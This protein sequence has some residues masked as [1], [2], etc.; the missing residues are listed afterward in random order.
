MP[1][2][3]PNI[4]RVAVG[5]VHHEGKILLAQRPEGKD[6]AGFWEFPGGKIEANEQV[7][8]ALVRELAEEVNLQL[9]AHQF[10]PLLQVTFNYP[11]KTVSLETLWVEA[12]AAQVQR[13]QGLEGQAIRWVALADLN[14]YRLP[15]AN[16]AILT[17]IRERLTPNA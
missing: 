15:E 3:V 11:H 12:S 4:V 9:G 5:V 2:T 14:D 1:T 17:K 7:A 6:F 8:D 13:A 10:S 16:L